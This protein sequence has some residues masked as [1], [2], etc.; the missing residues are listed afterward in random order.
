MIKTGLG[1]AQSS[2]KSFVKENC[3]KTARLRK[4]EKINIFGLKA[5]V[6]SK[7]Q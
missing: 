3:R 2:E 6:F 1:L 4:K 5:E 7:N